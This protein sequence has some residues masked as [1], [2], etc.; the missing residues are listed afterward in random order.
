[1]RVNARRCRPSGARQPVASEE[2]RGAVSAVARAS[3]ALAI[4][5]V[6][7]ARAAARRGCRL[8][9]TLGR[10]E[11]GP[12]RVARGRRRVALE[13]A[14]DHLQLRPG[15]ASSALRYCCPRGRVTLTVVVVD[16]AIVRG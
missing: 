4:D 11:G 15:S 7:A 1:M 8:S 5:S 2:H 9:E 3:V 6:S 13:R 16:G 12:V 14:V 10:L